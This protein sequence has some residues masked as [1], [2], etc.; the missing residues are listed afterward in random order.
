MSRIYSKNKAVYHRECIWLQCKIG[1][2]GLRK[3]IDTLSMLTPMTLNGMSMF[4]LLTFLLAGTC[5]IFPEP[6]FPI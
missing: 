6:P 4:C 3:D 5:G 2:G 1:I